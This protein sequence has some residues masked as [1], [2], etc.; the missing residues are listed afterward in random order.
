MRID[1]F[2][3]YLQ[4]EKRY[5]PHTIIAYRSDLN[6]YRGY[7]HHTYELEKIEESDHT[8]IR[9]WIVNLIDT[10]I[11]TKSINRKITS[12]KGFYKYLI[13]EG[14]VKAN[15]MNKILSPR[16]S[17]NLPVFVEEKK[18]A[19]LFREV[20]FGTDFR[21]VR[22]RLVMEFLYGT[23]VRLSELIHLKM[24]DLSFPDSSV[25][26]LGKRNKERIV[27][28]NE[29]LQEILIQYIEV[30]KNEFPGGKTP[31]Y[32]LLTDKGKQVYPKLVYRIVTRYLGQITT[33]QKRSPHVLR[34]TFATHLLNKGADINAIKE[35]LGHANLSATQVY[36][37][38]TIEKLKA[39]YSKAHPK[40]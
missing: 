20:E 32:L 7:L 36:T 28:L 17:K 33:M 38:N 37:H 35:L 23:G 25:K 27:P 2:I 31:E 19:L 9:S 3:H 30:R 24:N 39:A 5:S 12:L 1:K 40:A 29:I 11:S 6:Q 22:D 8:H 14:V 21:G 26:V 10:G 4:F 16:M 13:R 15:P 34:H 18:M